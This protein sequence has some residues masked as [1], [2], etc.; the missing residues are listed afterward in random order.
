MSSWDF[1]TP[2]IDKYSKE[3]NIDPKLVMAFCKVESS[4]NTWATR[5]EPLWKY[6]TAVN[7]FAD[8]AKTS[9]PTE[10]VHQ[11]TSWGLMQVMG[12]VARELGFT[13]S[14]PMLCNPEFG[15]LFG[16]KQLSRLQKYEISGGQNDWIASYNA[17]SPRKKSNGKY[18]N[19][20]YV[21]KLNKAY[22]EIA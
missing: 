4:W 8:S 21:D 19:Q 10:I 12:S 22:S 16:I 15:I 1:Y 9:I 5:Y 14:L 17:G 3:Y 20:D 2:I 11:S 7:N 13:E 6:T 18:E